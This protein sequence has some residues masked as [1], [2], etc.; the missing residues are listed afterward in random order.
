MPSPALLCSDFIN[1]YL[2]N[3]MPADSDE[4]AARK[5]EVELVVQ[6]R[7]E[8]LWYIEKVFE[9]GLFWLNV[10]LLEQRDIKMEPEALE[11]R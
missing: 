8:N 2:I 5:S 6:K 3:S 11:K 9:G 1:S 10:T 7:R 4:A